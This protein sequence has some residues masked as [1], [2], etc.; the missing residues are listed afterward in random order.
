MHSTV[1]DEHSFDQH[2]LKPNLP[3]DKTYKKFT[4]LH[5]CINNVN[6]T[7]TRKSNDGTDK[8]SDSITRYA[9]PPAKI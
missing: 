2:I 1:V 9:E 6:M 7:V 3:S 4:H 5:S 8:L